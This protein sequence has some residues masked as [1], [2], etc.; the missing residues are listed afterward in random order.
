MS[1]CVIKPK[2]RVR[3]FS[4]QDETGNRRKIKHT[5]Y[6]AVSNRRLRTL[7][8]QLETYS[9]YQQLILCWC[10]ETQTRTEIP[11]PWDTEVKAFP[12]HLC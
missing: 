10:Q 1:N 2:K 5:V 7:E 6:K 9:V 3:N 8:R 11:T 12:P 4:A